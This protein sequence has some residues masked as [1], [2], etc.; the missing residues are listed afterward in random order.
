VLDTNHAA[1]FV[2]GEVV[3]GIGCCSLGPC[4]KK[5]HGP[6]SPLDL[7]REDAMPSKEGCLADFGVSARKSQGPGV[8]L[9]ER[10]IASERPYQD[11]LASCL[12]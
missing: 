9:G 12:P 2:H 10:V 8:G 1:M 7:A 3:P 11:F 5:D 6:P 4:A